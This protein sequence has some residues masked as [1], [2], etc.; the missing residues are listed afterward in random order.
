MGKQIRFACPL[1]CF[2]ACSLVATVENGRVV[3]I[4]GDK[5]HPLTRGMVCSK[6]RGL[7]K[8]LYHPHRLQCPLKKKGTGWQ[9]LTWDEAICEIAD[10]LTGIK[11]KYGSQAVLHY[12]DSGYGGIIKSVDAIFFN[13]YGP[14]TVPSGS[15]CWGAGIAAQKFDFGDVLG[16]SPDDLANARTIIVWGRNPADTNPHL[17]PYLRQARKKGAVVILI[18]PISTATLQYVDLHLPVRPST[19]G[20]L[21]LGMASHIIAQGLAD[22]A[23]VHD[24]VLGFRRFRAYA[25]NFTMDRVARLTGLEPSIIK[26]VAERYACQKPGCIMVGIGL[27]RY[28]NGGGTIRCIDALGA[29]TGN[30]GIAGGGVNYANRGSARY[31]AGETPGRHGPAVNRRYFS[32]PQMGTFLNTATDPRIHCVFIAKANPLVQ[33]P[34]LHKT[35]AAFDR[36][37]F[38][39]V[40]DMFMTDTARHADLVLPC[41]SVLEE[42]DIICSAMYSPYVNYSARAVDSPV[43]IMGEYE[44]FAAL[45]GKMH[46]DNYPFMPPMDFLKRAVGPLLAACHS[47]FK[48]LTDGSLKPAGMDIPWQDKSFATPSGKYELYSASALRAGQK[49]LP[50]FKDPLKHPS[51]F[52]LRLLTPHCKGAMHSQGFSFTDD[53]PT[54]HVNPLVLAEKKLTGQLFA[55]VVSPN[56]RL[57]VRLKPSGAIPEGIVMIYQGRWHKS[58]AVNFLTDDALSDMGEQATYYDTFCD[59]E[60]HG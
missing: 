59:L 54:A 22:G 49:P 27:Q 2:D 60:P 36:V 21:A 31:L 56:G 4:R 16:H 35:I 42:E 32:L 53:P 25:S 40:T 7:L 50:Y 26:Q 13:C 11:Q 15:L 58:G 48:S 14:V 12:S 1:D 9:T 3:R 5:A 47:D 52:D 38:K 33:M 51:G 44:F 20:A 55:W 10:K 24:Q 46:L 28:R 17:I 39:V 34:H 45:A 57:Q 43:G 6:G 41:T 30:I 29:I 8:R 23:F 19:D 18:D 37:P